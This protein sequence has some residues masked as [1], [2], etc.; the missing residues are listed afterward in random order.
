[1]PKAALLIL[2]LF[3]AACGGRAHD[4]G[5]VELRPRAP[6]ARRRPPGNVTQP[7]DRGRTGTVAETIDAGPHLPAPEDREQR[8]LGRSERGWLKAGTEVTVGNAI[9]M[10]NFE[11]DAQPQVRPDSL[12]QPDDGRRRRPLPP[13]RPGIRPLRPWRRLP[14]SG[15]TPRPA[16]DQGD[17]K[18][19]KRRA[20]TAR[21][22]P[23]STRT[24]RPSR[25]VEV[26]VRGRV[27]KFNPEIM[28]RN[29]LHLRDGSGSAEKQDNDITIT[30]SDVVAKATS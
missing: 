23:R 10:A 22:W 5:R 13:F 9:W 30:T 20:R 29:W 18:G 25:G 1:M 7:G 2:P 28:G 3:L 26:V 8:G 14:A 27:V 15:A 12:R 11:Q 16:A 19:R 21:R 4:R 24:R 6:A 17:V